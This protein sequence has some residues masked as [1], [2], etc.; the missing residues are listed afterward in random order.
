MKTNVK[1]HNSGNAEELFRDA[2][3]SED[4]GDFSGAFGSHMAAA[5]LGNVLSQL[6]LGN[7]YSSGKGVEKNLREAARWYIKA[8]RGG[9]SAGAINLAVDLQTQGN[10]RGAISWLKRAAAMNDGDACVQLA[11]ILL[12]R[13]GGTKNA[14][15]LLRKAASFSSSDISDEARE[16]AEALLKSIE[17][18]Q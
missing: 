6:S 7:F 10:M 12:K 18:A 5:Q 14:V 9:V 15:D 17:I 11:G 4:R 3:R 16:Q 8:Y 13:R 2:E 1:Q